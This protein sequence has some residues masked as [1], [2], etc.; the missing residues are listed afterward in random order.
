MRVL[1][2]SNAAQIGG[3]NRALLTLAQGLRAQGVVP[4]VI[5]PS[6]GPMVSACADAG[7]ICDIVPYRQP[8]WRQPI[9]TWRAMRAWRAVFA[10]VRPD[11]IHA[12]DFHNARAVMIAAGRRVPVVCHIRFHQKEAYLRWVFRGLPKPVAFVHNSQAT[13][14]VVEPVLREACPV[15]E[16]VVIYNGV[17][18]DRFVPAA[19]REKTGPARIGIVGNLIPIKGHE[20]FLLMARQLTDQAFDGEYWIVGEDIHGTGYRERLTARARARG[21]DARVRFLGHRSDVP[22]LLRQLDVLVCASHV[23]PFGINVIEGMACEL[24]VV[25][26]RVGG[27][28]EIIEEGVTG[29]LVPP[30]DAA[31][32]AEAVAALLRDPARRRQMGEAGRRR[33]QRLFSVETYTAEVLALYRR[34]LSRHGQPAS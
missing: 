5:V 24:P 9:A 15:A 1:Y 3:A 7:L 12:N 18:L 33:V 29:S 10:R 25:G 26:T 17:P 19:I 13:R 2:L 21:I 14:A 6:D 22:D 23:E 8:G 20:E 32:L 30:A 4:H 31:R 28:P 34:V 16:Q 11:L 27:I